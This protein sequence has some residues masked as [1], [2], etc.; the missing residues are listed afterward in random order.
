MSLGCS[1]VVDRIASRGGSLRHDSGQPNGCAANDLF[2][3]GT[4]HAKL[5]SNGRHIS[6]AERQVRLAGVSKVPPVQG[7]SL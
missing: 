6:D 5:Q 1:K 7:H 4:G 2:D 3:V